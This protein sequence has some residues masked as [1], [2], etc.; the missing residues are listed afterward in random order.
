[1]KTLS[2]FKQS[3]FKLDFEFDGPEIIDEGPWHKAD[4]ISTFGDSLNECLDN[5]TVFYTD[6]DG[7]EHRTSSAEDEQSI[8]A[9]RLEFEAR[10]GLYLQEYQVDLYKNQK[11]D[12]TIIVWTSD[13]S[14]AYDLV[15]SIVKAA[16]GVKRLREIG[17]RLVSML[18]F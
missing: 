14:A 7:G 12:K 18:K 10:Y 16:T 4:F 17:V 2:D 9:I 8:E 5:A 11:L 15:E 13:Y 1:M 3:K 6:Q